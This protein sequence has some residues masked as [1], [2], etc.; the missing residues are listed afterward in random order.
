[1]DLNGFYNLPLFNSLDSFSLHTPFL[2]Y[3]FP[4]Y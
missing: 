3:G 2:S 1:M 4:A